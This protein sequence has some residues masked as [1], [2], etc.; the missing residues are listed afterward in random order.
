M[1]LPLLL[2]TLSPLLLGATFPTTEVDCLTANI[3]HE[4]RGESIHG[5]WLVAYVT[6][7]RV[8]SAHYPDTYCSVVKQP[9][10]FS[11]WHGKAL[12]PSDKKAWEVARQIAEHFILND[13]ISRHDAS[14]GALYYHTIK[15]HPKWA[16]TKT[17]IG[18]VGKHLAYK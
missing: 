17:Y 7:N 8:N 9:A 10:Q 14:L 3:Y 2:L 18:R 11:W 13:P 15:V 6:R 12:Y 16:N 5:Q 4:A 1:K